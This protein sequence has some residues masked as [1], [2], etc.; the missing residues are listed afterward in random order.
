[1]G[2][3]N[4]AHLLKKRRTALN[5]TQSKVAQ[6]CYMS[7][8]CYNH[9]ENGKRLPSLNTLFHLSSA[10]N[11]PLSEFM[12]AIQ[13]EDKSNS[14]PPDSEILREAPYN[15]YLQNKIID[16]FC[17]LDEPEQKAVIDIIDSLLSPNL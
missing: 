2:I 11:T 5:L 4:F 7:K 16:S 12:S 13:S 1:M 8:S 10:L 3:E 17:L 9:F 6:L 15:S 14:N